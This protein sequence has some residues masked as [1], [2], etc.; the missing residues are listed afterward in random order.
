MEKP[1]LVAIFAHPD[2]EAF[3]PGGTLA[4]YSKTHDT[5]LICVTH[6]E[7]GHNHKGEANG[8]GSV[9][10]KE[11]LASAKVLGIK[12][13]FCLDY[14]DGTLANFMYRDIARDIRE[15]TDKLKPEIFLTF[16]QCGVSGHIDHITVAMITQYL[17]YRLEY[18]KELMMFCISEEEAAA[19]R[20]DYFIYIPTGYDPEK[21]DKIIDISAVYNTRIRA[22]KTHKS[23]MKDI[24]T[25]LKIQKNLP[26]QELFFVKNK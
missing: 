18:V 7:A 17:F 8:L 21:V 15:I 5:Y 16:D 26:K 10:E 20:P 4:L 14:F 1:K 25:F 23:Q 22:L 12:Q 6:G 3:G 13:V 11:L 24:I 9:R 19:T 2:D